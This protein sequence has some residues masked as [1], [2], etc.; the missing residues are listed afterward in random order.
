MYED[1]HLE[2]DYEDRFISDAE[3]DEYN[4]YIADRLDEECEDDEDETD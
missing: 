2:M 4:A 3:W 1:S